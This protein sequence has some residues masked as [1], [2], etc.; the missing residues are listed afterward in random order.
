MCSWWG[1]P[2]TGPLSGKYDSGAVMIRV[3]VGR[4]MDGGFVILEEH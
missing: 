3:T 4:L 1:T 2:G